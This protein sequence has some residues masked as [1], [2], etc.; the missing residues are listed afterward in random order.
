MLECM[1][2]L[3]IFS[4]GVLGI[5][6][7]QALATQ[8]SV[9]S[10]DRAIAATL[11]NDLIA[12]LWTNGSVA[13]PADYTTWQGYVTGALASGSGT[14]KTAGSVATVTITWKRKA[15]DPVATDPFYT[16]TYSTQVTIQ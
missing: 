4:I 13:T 15:D 16:A 3:A 6:M 7:M 11:A 8:N 12:E 2:A 9:N 14:L 1:I 5:V 10:E